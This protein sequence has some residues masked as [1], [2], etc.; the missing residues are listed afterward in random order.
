MRGEIEQSLPCRFEQQVRRWPGKLAV[1][2]RAES[3]TYAELDGLA[4][5]IAHAVLAAAGDANEPVA[6]RIRREALFIAAIL[7]VLKAGKI[8]AAGSDRSVRW[9]PN[10]NT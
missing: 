3:L 4:N 9:K 2:T 1:K 8:S 7:G 10:D 6:L 5:R